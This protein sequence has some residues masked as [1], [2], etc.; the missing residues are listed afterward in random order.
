MQVK[1][2]VPFYRW[3][4]LSL[5]SGYSHLMCRRF[6][7]PATYHACGDFSSLFALYFCEFVLAW[8]KSFALTFCSELKDWNGIPC[9]GKWV[10]VLPLMTILTYNNKSFCC[11][12]PSTG[13]WDFQFRQCI[14]S[15]F[16]FKSHFSKTAWGLVSFSVPARAF[17]LLS[18]LCSTHL[19]PKGLINSTGEHHF[20][21][22]N[23]R[24]LA[25]LQRP[26]SS[27][28]NL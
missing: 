23:T 24:W 22:R 11:Q 19:F 13:W 1:A 27:K 25:L 10:C 17:L 12:K 5:I 21:Q 20:S 14:C 26:L 3:M 8:G 2:A 28:P 7:W 18:P 16:F 9:M 4:Q 6:M 15:L